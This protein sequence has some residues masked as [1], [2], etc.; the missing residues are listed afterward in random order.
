VKPNISAKAFLATKQRIP[1][2]GN[3]VL[4]D[5]LWNERIQISFGN[6]PAHCCHMLFFRLFPSLFLIATLQKGF[7]WKA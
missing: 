3:E 6:F 1:G 2:F 4:L 5:A 7:V